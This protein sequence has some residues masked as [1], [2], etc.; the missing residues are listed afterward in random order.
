MREF[1]VCVCPDVCVCVTVQQ[2]VLLCLQL[3]VRTEPTQ[4][5]LS[6][7]PGLPVAAALYGQAGAAQ[8]VHSRGSPQS[9]V[10]YRTQVI[11]HG[12]R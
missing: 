6:G 1:S 5:L 11:C 9:G 4:P 12:A 8:S 2:E 3:C 10:T 7:Q